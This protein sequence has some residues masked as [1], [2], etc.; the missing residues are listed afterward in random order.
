MRQADMLGRVG[1]IGVIEIVGGQCLGSAA[2]RVLFLLSNWVLRPSDRH[3]WWSIIC[4][5]LLMN[6]TSR[7]LSKQLLDGDVLASADLHEIRPNI[8]SKLHRLISRYLSIR[9]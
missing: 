3:R 1:A 7:N 9:C 8:T 4:D 2:A 6:H 5:L